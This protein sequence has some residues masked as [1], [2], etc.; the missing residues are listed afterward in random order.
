MDTRRAASLATFS[1]AVE[2]LH[3][4]Y[5]TPQ[6]N[7]SHYGCRSVSLQGGGC[8][9]TASS[10]LPFSFNAS[11]YTAEELTEKQ[12]NFQLA[13]S[14]HTILHLD[15]R[16]SGIGSNSCGPALEEQYRFQEPEFT[17]ELNL[18]FEK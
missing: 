5:L 6:E 10:P 15:Y 7:G 8:K 14:G 9:L 16:Q 4:A 18:R 17:Y 1:A 2:A 13:P 12:H 11:P 3:A